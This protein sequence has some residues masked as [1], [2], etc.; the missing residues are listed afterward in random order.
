MNPLSMQSGEVG[1]DFSGRISTQL[2]NVLNG[3][4]FGDDNMA[5]NSY[6]AF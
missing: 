2:S 3:G 5:R 4:R 1:N 6:E